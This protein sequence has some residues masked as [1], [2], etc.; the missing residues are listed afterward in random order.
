MENNN[1]KI[2]WYIFTGFMFV[3]IGAGIAFDK[4]EVGVLIGIGLGFIAA[5]VYRSEKSK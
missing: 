3:G 2:G 4:P 1:K 5:A